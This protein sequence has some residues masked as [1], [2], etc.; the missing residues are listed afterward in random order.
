MEVL[1]KITIYDLLGYTVP[2]T[3]LVGIME[4]CFV[5]PRLSM[6]DCEKYIGYICAVTILMGYV[7]GIAISELAGMI[8]SIIRKLAEIAFPKVKT[9]IE[10]F[11]LAV[12]MLV[13]KIFLKIRK[14]SEI[15]NI[16]AAIVT[17][18]LINAKII[19][20]S[21]QPLT[22]KDIKKYYGYMYACVQTD[23][24]YSRIHNY[25]SSELVCKNLAIVFLISTILLCKFRA[26][27]IFRLGLTTGRVM[28]I[29]L[30]GAIFCAKRGLKQESRKDDYMIDWFVQKYIS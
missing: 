7:T 25:A 6:Q 11:P 16:E 3:I 27:M 28:L 18:A 17:T 29:G 5:L 19:Q 22:A 20:G 24:N 23:A 12:Q 30:V 2:G 4:I 9:W 13:K 15:E 26:S 21:P 10:K 14:S 1:Q 8:F